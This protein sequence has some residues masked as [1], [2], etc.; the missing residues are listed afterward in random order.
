MLAIMGHSGTIWVQDRPGFGSGTKLIV[1][2]TPA[3]R[4]SRDRRPNGVAPNLEPILAAMGNLLA[5]TP[6]KAG[7]LLMVQDNEGTPQFLLHDS[8]DFTWS[9]MTAVPGIKGLYFAQALTDPA[10]GYI[11]VLPSTKNAFTYATCFSPGAFTLV[12]LTQV[13]TMR[14]QQFAVRPSHIVDD[15]AAPNM[16]ELMT[17]RLLS[18]AQAEFAKHNPVWRSALMPSALCGSLLDGSW[19]N[20]QLAALAAL[21]AKRRGLAEDVNQLLEQY[22]PAVSCSFAGDLDALRPIPSAAAQSRPLLLNAWMLHCEDN[23]PGNFPKGQIDSGGLWLSWY[24]VAL[25]KP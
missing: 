6:E 24:A 1:Y 10:Y 9:R 12:T 13:S 8:P 15:W 4:H 19:R 23:Q 17:T 5:L 20:G 7:L 2:G 14:V 18:S 25:P 11:S 22:L 21:D 16:S 3:K